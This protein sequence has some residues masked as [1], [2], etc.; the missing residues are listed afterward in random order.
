[1]LTENAES[2]PQRKCLMCNEGTPSKPENHLCD[3]CLKPVKGISLSERGVGKAISDHILSKANQLTKTYGL[4]AGDKEAMMQDLTLK[5]LKVLKTCKPKT[6]TETTYIKISL[7]NCSADIATEVKNAPR[8]AN[9]EDTLQ[10]A[11]MDD[12]Y[13]KNKNPE[14]PYRPLTIST[15]IVLEQL[16]VNDH[17]YILPL[18]MDIE[19]VF[20]TFTSRQRHIAYM[21][22]DGMTQEKIAEKLGIAQQNVNKQIMKI[23]TI[24]KKL[25]KM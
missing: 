8:H 23:R 6:A 4:Q 9:A 21:L 20:P 17:E 16:A 2:T 7:E 13:R 25:W 19:S 5:A 11:E 10:I 14:G 24:F 22:E 1:M 18:K 12:R 3:D 15:G